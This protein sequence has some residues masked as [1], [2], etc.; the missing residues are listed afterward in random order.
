MIS[1]KGLKLFLLGFVGAL[2][3]KTGEKA[4]FSKSGIGSIDETS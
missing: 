2:D 4:N 3:L 1:L